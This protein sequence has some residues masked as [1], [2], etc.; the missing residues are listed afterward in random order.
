M[1]SQAFSSNIREDPRLEAAR[2]GLNQFVISPLIQGSNLL[3][4]YYNTAADSAIDILE[5][6]F[7]LKLNRTTQPPK[8]KEDK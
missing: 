4:S 2:V 7:G 8:D 6:N 1:L 5:Y 3:A